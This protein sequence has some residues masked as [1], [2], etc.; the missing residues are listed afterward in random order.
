[1]SSWEDF[2]P[3]IFDQNR[4][5]EAGPEVDAAVALAGAAPG[6]AV[7]DLACGPGR[8]SLEL[9]RRGF[10]VTG[11]DLTAAF[12]ET[13]G[14]L[15]EQ[16]GLS[17]EFVCEDMLQFRREDSFDAAFVFSTSFGYFE[18]P[19]DDVAVLR[20]VRAS[21]HHGGVLLMELLGKEVV[22]R[23]L[24]GPTWHEENGV[25]LLTDQQVR[26]D[27]TWVD[28]RF[29]FLGGEGRADFVLTHRLYSAGELKTALREAGF[30]DVRCF[31][32]LTG[33]PYAA[34]ATRLVAVAR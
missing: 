7:L 26:D 32:D 17:A 14:K 3:I 10:T 25:L 19:A 31:G 18:D 21:L 33:S 8:H 1:M 27:W 24:R 11:V 2:A 12:V 6:A 30:E 28:H 29:A 4:W 9:A 13:A 23:T 34:D 22:A 20:N 15:A 5:A 16:Q